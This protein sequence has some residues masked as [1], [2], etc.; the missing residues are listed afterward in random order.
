LKAFAGRIRTSITLVTSSSARA[1]VPGTA[2]LAAVNGALTAMVGPLAAEL[3]PLRVN[4]VAP[5]VIRTPWWDSTPFEQREAA[6]AGVAATMPAGRVG[7]PEEVAEA[8][9][10]LATNG[11]VTGTVLDCA[12][13]GHLALWHGRT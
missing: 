10:F 9:L 13:G 7:E 5:G 6:F 4:A 8:I 1:A 12:G 3:A 11:Y 2:G